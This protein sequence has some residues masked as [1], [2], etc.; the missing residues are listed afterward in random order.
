MNL[1]KQEK[2]R[3]IIWLR[4]IPNA[5]FLKIAILWE[6]RFIPKKDFELTTFLPDKYSSL[7]GWI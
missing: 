6:L 3:P 1:E 5:E 4:L 7:I 2:S